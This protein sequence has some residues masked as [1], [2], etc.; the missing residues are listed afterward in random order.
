MLTNGEICGPGKNEG[1]IRKFRPIMYEGAD[2][3]V[4]ALNGNYTGERL[5][6]TATNLRELNET[7]PR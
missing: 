7:D 1:E 3:W 6:F 4:E 5:T 2:V